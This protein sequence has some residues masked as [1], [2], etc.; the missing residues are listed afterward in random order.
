ML[1]AGP[2]SVSLPISVGGSPGVL[3][4]SDVLL[5]VDIGATSAPLSS[6]GVPPGH[7]AADNLDPALVSYD[8]AGQQ[9]GTGAGTLCE[10]VSASSLAQ[11]PAPADLIGSG[12]LSCWQGYTAH[13]SLLGVLI[14]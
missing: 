10:K 11:I 13:N 12:L 7:V 3:D 5:Q 9:T 1:S 2:G 14:K 8:T 4:M 6:T